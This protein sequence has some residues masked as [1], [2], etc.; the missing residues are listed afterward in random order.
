M[1]IVVDNLIIGAGYS[2]LI[3]QKKLA[4]IGQ[5]SIIVERG[6]NHGYGDDDYVTICKNKLPFIKDEIAVITK[7]IS[8]GHKNF[9]KEF[10]EKVY[11]KVID[12][13]TF[14]K[15][16]SEE[17]SYSI[18]NK[19]LLDDANCYGNIDIN[20]I[21]IAKKICYGQV[22]HLKSI[23]EFHYNKLVS[24]I[25]IYEFQKLVS[26]NYLKQF[27]IFISYYP[28]GIKKYKSIDSHDKMVIEYY[29]DPNIPFYRKQQ[30]GNSIYY[31]Y[32]L[33]KPFNDKFQA[34]IKPGKFIKIND[35]KMSQLYDYY[36]GKDIY[37]SGR[38]ATW[39]TDFLLDN[40][41]E[42]SQSISNQI[43]SELYGSF[44]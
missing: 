14:Y 38:F 15:E 23:V 5:Q 10:T 42:P 9:S 26:A 19:Y 31:E 28:I 12:I 22:S 39:D 33:N 6:F 20:K 41:W 11:N 30:Y 3:L 17:I 40:I 8:S 34:I 16:E 2:G 4:S 32:C 7:K 13:D 37:F 29:S 36:I 18:N 24:T 1:Q 43:L 27:G 21:D 35:N 25:P 44:K